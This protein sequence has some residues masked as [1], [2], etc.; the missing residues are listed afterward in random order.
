MVIQIINEETSPITCTS[1]SDI[2][3]NTCAIEA[4]ALERFLA[5]HSSR[6]VVHLHTANNN[7]AR[8]LAQNLLTLDVH[9]TVHQ[10]HLATAGLEPSGLHIL[11][12]ATLAQSLVH[13]QELVQR[14]LNLLRER[15]HL[16]EDRCV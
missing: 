9:S 14:K 13:A 11:E 16:E 5:Q 8:R 10:D 15:V 2:I 7:Q 6:S 3:V 12:Y 4:N 1:S